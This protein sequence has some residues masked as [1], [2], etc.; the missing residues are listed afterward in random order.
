[1]LLKEKANKKVLMLKQ[2]DI[3]PNPAQPRREFEYAQLKALADSILENGILQPLTVRRRENEKFEL[4]AGE[5]RLRASKMAGLK[6][7]PCLLMDASDKQSAIFAM[8]ENIQRK[9]LDFFEEAEGIARLLTDWGIPREQV[10]RQ[11][12]IAP[13]TL[14][15]KIRLL[16]LSAVERALIG[17]AALTERHARAFIRIDDEKERLE[18]IEKTCREHLNVEQTERLIESVLAQKK[19]YDRKAHRILFVKDIR[20]FVNTINKA[21]SVMVGAGVNATSERRETDTSIEYLVRI[22]K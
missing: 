3:L 10:C 4:I 14:A 18:L 17:G 7:V 1:M 22:P 19:S 8:I 15:N 2:E 12:G 16:K 21:I 9:D 5:R 6:E 13:S 11:L 20:L